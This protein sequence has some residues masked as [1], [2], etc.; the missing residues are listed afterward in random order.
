MKREEALKNIPKQGFIKL[1]RDQ[2]PT[3]SREQRTA[4]IRRG[5]EL[6]NKGE[7]E[8]AKKIFITTGYS[9]GIKRIGDYYISK[10]KVLE[11]FRMYNL[12][13]AQQEIDNMIEQMAGV[14]RHWL[15]EG[16]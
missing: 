1:T 3:L 11:A 10:K 13:P 15:K 6:F 12:A 8:K 9:D 2:G 16:K 5:N 14:V 7:Y 4:L